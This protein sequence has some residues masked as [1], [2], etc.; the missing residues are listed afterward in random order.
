MFFGVARNLRL[1]TALK[2]AN[3]RISMDGR[4]PLDG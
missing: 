1:T 3:I 4:G 2:E